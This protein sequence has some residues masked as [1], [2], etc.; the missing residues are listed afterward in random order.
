MG[1]ADDRSDSL[2]SCRGL[3]HF[4]LS[5]FDVDLEQVHGLVEKL[6]EGHCRD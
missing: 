4:E 3:Q 5:S 1:L 2:Q 6:V